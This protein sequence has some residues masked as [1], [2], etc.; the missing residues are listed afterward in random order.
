LRQVIEIFLLSSSLSSNCATSFN[1]SF[2]N[3]DS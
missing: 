3:S 1:S 2:K